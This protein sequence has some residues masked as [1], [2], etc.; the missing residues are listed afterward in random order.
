MED[1]DRESLENKTQ[2][3][4]QE[5]EIVDF[6]QTAWKLPMPDLI[7]SVT[8]GATAFKIRS[9]I[10]LKLFQQDMVSAAVN[11]NAWIFTGGTYSGVMKEV[12]H[13]LNVCC[14]QGRKL[15]STIP[16]IGIVNWYATTDHRQLENTTHEKSNT[17][18]PDMTESIN[19]QTRR[20]ERLYRTR[21][22][23]NNEKPPTYP[24]D[25]NHTHYLMLD[26]GFEEKGDRSQRSDYSDLDLFEVIL[27]I[28]AKIEEESRTV[29]NKQSNDL[30]PIVQIVVNGGPSTVLTV[31]EAVKQKTP[32]LGTDRAADMIASEYEYLYGSDEE[33]SRDKYKEA[34]KQKKF[35]EYEKKVE[36]E[37]DPGESILKSKNRP[38][39]IKMMTTID[40]YFLLN[41]FTLSDE[42]RKGKLEDAIME[43]QRNAASL[44]AMKPEQMSKSQLMLSMTWGKYDEVTNNKFISDTA[45]KWSDIDLD[46]LLR[47]ALY[48]KSVNYI[49]MVTEY[50][51]SFDRL[52]R[53]LDVD[54][55]YNELVDSSCQAQLPPIRESGQP[56]EL[57]SEIEL[58]SSDENECFIFNLNN[59]KKNQGRKHYFKEYFDKKITDNYLLNNQEVH[60]S[61]QSHKYGVIDG[62]RTHESSL[63]GMVVFSDN[64]SVRKS[65]QV[66]ELSIH[67][68]KSDPKSW[69]KGPHKIFLYIIAKQESHEFVIIHRY[70]LPEIKIEDFIKDEAK[71]ER[72]TNKNSYIFTIKMHE[73]TLYLTKDQFLGIGFSSDTP[74]A[75]L[76]KG[77][78]SYY[79]D[80]NTANA[81]LETGAAHSFIR[82]A[83]YCPTF[84]FTITTTSSFVRDLLF[85]SLFADNSRL[86][87]CLCS[88]SEDSIVAALLA[89]MIYE[90]AAELAYEENKENEYR[91]KATKFDDHAAQIIEQC[92][93]TDRKF[94]LGL[95]ET[96]STVYFDYTPLQLAK[97]NHS[98]SF[99]ATKCVQNYLDKLWYGDINYEELRYS[100]AWIRFLIILLCTF[101]MVIPLIACCNTKFSNALGL[102]KEE[103]Y[104]VLVDYFPL[105]NNGGRR[106]GDMDIYIPITE[107]LVHMFMWSV[108]IEEVIEFV[109]FWWESSRM[110]SVGDIFIYFY[111]DKWNVLDLF[112]F[113][114]Y[115]VGFVTRF[116]PNEPAFDASKICMCILLLLWYIR[117]LHFFIASEKLGF[118]LLM[119]FYTL[120]DLS[121]FVFFILV[122][123]IGYSVT[124]YALITTEQ[125]VFWNQTLGNTS[126]TT[127]TL[128]QGGSGIW[129]WTILRNIIDWGMW[130]IY[131]QVDLLGYSEADGTTLNGMLHYLILLC[132]T[133][134]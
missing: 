103:N 69:T 14:Y 118:R 71:P 65:G 96:K 110:S 105:N 72:S 115:L 43:A 124:S 15:A 46:D 80:L 36:A 13:A 101:P 51:A 6:M 62:R 12:G 34:E 130:K 21:K 49:E 52:R 8:G 74:K 131:G 82:Q 109:T 116:F 20:H 24:L 121:F 53:F 44:A 127:Y 30:I 47:E 41:T 2:S 117:T 73:P 114:F 108:F 83:K 31:C 45:V 85:W 35:E 22:P 37:L 102:T 91:Q 59:T 63:N 86:A 79:I 54:N 76:V 87:T 68:C 11:T 19:K 111:F 25:H 23:E 89:S 78:T 84:T 88:H 55:L 58:I 7:I 40:G 107:I 16:C 33:R 75:Y 66:T 93:R 39:F 29:K 126:S 57:R 128:F 129:N 123:L 56:T 92:Y 90:T 100:M 95:L 61:A 28:R 122:F 99:L 32:V 50:G 113:A 10:L 132:W 3:K 134:S 104:V 81:I 38:D 94:A 106:S 98:R 77:N 27:K 1:D 119:I 26:D 48:R 9:S 5:A 18:S 133:S 64:G 60:H 4:S 125:Q 70:A 17:N 67:F 97:K 112:A 42:S 120:K